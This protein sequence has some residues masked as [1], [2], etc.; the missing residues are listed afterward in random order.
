MEISFNKCE[1]T[2]C[3]PLLCLL[4][5]AEYAE[6]ICFASCI[7]FYWVL[8]GI[9]VSRS[10]VGMMVFDRFVCLRG[11]LNTVT[12]QRF[13]FSLLPIARGTWVYIY[14]Y[15]YTR[16]SYICIPPES[17]SPTLLGHCPFCALG[18]LGR[19]GKIADGDE[20]TVGV[21]DGIRSR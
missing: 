2:H 4:T 18:R 13:V 21:Q 7:G 11:F 5:G 9:S 3:I 19:F 17:K 15:I 1:I 12:M 16:Y 8:R 20:E 10:L 6:S 14:I